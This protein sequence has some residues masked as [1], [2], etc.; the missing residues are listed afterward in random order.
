MWW[1]RHTRVLWW[2]RHTRVKPIV[3][4]DALVDTIKIQNAKIVWYKYLG[5]I[6]EN[7]KQE[8]FT[9]NPNS[10]KQCLKTY[11][12]K[13]SCHKRKLGSLVDINMK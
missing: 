4:T 6:W 13:H 8:K 9:L 5:K 1:Q 2:Q 10:L 11:S 3:S 12:Q 7:L